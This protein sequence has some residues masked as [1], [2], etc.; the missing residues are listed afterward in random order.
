M[1]GYRAVIDEIRS[2]GQHAVTAGEDSRKVDLPASVAGVEPA[3][4]GSAAAIAARALSSMWESRLRLLSDDVT[5]LGADLEDS[6]ARYARDDAAAK[7]NLD[8]AGDPVDPRHRR[9]E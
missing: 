7:A 9:Y 5:R 8:S 4:P 3:L 2:C 6:A 1:D